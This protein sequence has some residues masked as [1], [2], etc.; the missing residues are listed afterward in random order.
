MTEPRKYASAVAA[1][2]ERVFSE[3]FRQRVAC[4]R[5]NRFDGKVGP[6]PLA[7]TLRALLPF[8]RRIIL[9]VNAGLHCGDTDGK[10]AESVEGIVTNLRH[11]RWT[12]VGQV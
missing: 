1:V 6:E 7:I 4:R 12:T 2:I 9:L 3:G 8:G 5:A 11:L 10:R